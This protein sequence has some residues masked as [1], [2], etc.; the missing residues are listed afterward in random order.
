MG[1]K[2]TYWAAW[3]DRKDEP[4]II[5]AVYTGKIAAMNF[6]ARE[7]RANKVILVWSSADTNGNNYMEFETG[8]DG[9]VL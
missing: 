4:R 7:R 9:R 3:A 2:H 5:P 6:A 1:E 8:C